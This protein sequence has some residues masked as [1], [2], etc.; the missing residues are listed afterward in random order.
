MLLPVS[1]F[2]VASS[3]SRP[4]RSLGRDLDFMREA[5]AR[6]LQAL[7]EL[8]ATE[9]IGAGPHERTATRTNQRNGG[10]DRLLSTKA[11]DVELRIPKLRHGSFFPAVLERRRR[12]DRAVAEGAIH[13]L[14][15]RDQRLAG[16]HRLGQ[17]IAKTLERPW[18]DQ[19]HK[20]L[21]NIRQH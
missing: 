21:P 4:T 18:F 1:V 3:V 13:R 20:V 2:E 8:G 7:R 19:R 9:V 17:I 15:R 14:R 11:G 16:H 10:R 6:V 5:M 12:I